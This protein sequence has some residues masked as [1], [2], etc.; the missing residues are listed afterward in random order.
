MGRKTKLTLDQWFKVAQ[1]VRLAAKLLERVASAVLPASSTVKI[2][3]RVAK[4]ANTYIARAKS[5]LEDEAIRQHP[6]DADAIMDAFYGDETT[7]RWTQRS[8][9]AR[10]Y[11]A[12]AQP[13]KRWRPSEVPLCAEAETDADGVFRVYLWDKDGGKASF[14]AD[15]AKGLARYLSEEVIPKLDKE[16]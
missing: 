1:D 12:D 9:D 13:C 5:A 15:L 2:Y 3:D 8:N 6:G 14:P 16:A 10:V 4:V 7:R 11:P